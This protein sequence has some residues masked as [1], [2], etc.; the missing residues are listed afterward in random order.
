MLSF[1]AKFLTDR[2]ADT[3]KTILHPPPTHCLS[4][5]GHKKFRS[6]S[7]C[8]TIVLTHYHAMPYFDALQIIIMAVKKKKNVR[9]GD[10][11]CN[12]QF[13]LFLQCFLLYIALI[14]F[15]FF[16]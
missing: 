9:K 1:Y 2:R 8:A 14:Y 7:A 12:K 11:V 13:L 3:G 15:F 10:I 4:I 6:L 5:Q 16:F